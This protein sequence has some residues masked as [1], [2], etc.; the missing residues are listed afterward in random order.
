ME[1]TRAL[2]TGLWK[3]ITGCAFYATAQ[4]LFKLVLHGLN[5]VTSVGISTAGRNAGGLYD[6]QSAV[7]AFW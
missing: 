1:L 3:G 2:I 6:F 4:G 7:V 5:Q